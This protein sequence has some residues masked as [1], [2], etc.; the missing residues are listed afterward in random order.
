MATFSDKVIRGDIKN[1]NK[2]RPQAVTLLDIAKRLNVSPTTVSYVIRNRADELGVSEETAKRVKEVA[3]DL[4]YIP[5][6]IARSLQNGKTGIVSV[7]ITALGSMDW[8]EMILR[9]I[10]EV[11]VH[12]GYL[13]LIIRQNEQYLRIES[14][15]LSE[16][17]LAS[18]ILPRRDEG[19]ICHPNYMFRNDYVT[20]CRSGIPVVFFGTLPVDMTGL[21]RASS[22]TWNCAP[23]VKHAVNHLVSLGRTR[24]AF[25]GANHGDQSD[26]VRL[27]A[28]NE[29]LQENNIP[30][31][32]DWY[33]WWPAY[34]ADKI[35]PS[36]ADQLIRLFEKGRN[37]PS[38]IFALNDSI[39]IKVLEIL[40]SIGLRVPEEVAVIGMGNYQITGLH[41]VNL[42]TMEEPMEQMGR[43]AA[44]LLLK[45]I[46]D[47]NSEPEHKQISWNKLVA[48]KSTVG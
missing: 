12:A 26:K 28:F 3:R 44:R 5:N 10:E 8:A 38:A 20:L 31:N 21:E 25:V 47:P 18:A 37:T 45:R 13:P 14:S 33:I 9:G 6:Q 19:V 4:G 34:P 1:S 23:P 11:L 15:Y 7:L 43:E 22:V 29:A 27:Q 41:G 42:S 17:G 24:I 35:T 40:A 32:P 39:A 2:M 48:R 16:K 46:R 30:L 36:S